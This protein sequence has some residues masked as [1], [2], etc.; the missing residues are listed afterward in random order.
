MYGRVTDFILWKV[1]THEWPVFNVAD[2]ALVVGVIGLL[3]RRQAGRAGERQPV[4][5]A[6]EREE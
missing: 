2:A 6:T 3:L 4:E 5:P 1:H